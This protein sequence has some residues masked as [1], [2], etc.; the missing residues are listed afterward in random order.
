MES[1]E[2]RSKEDALRVRARA[3]ETDSLAVAIVN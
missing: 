2:G 1:C 3:R